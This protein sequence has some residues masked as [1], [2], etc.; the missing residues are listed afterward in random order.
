M[1]EERIENAN[2]SQAEAVATPEAIAQAKATLRRQTKNIRRALDGEARDLAYADITAN[3]CAIPEFQQAKAVFAYVSTEDEVD[4][5]ALIARAWEAGKAVYAPR[6][7]GPRTMEWHAIE[8]FDGLERSAFGIDEPAADP[9]SAVD[10]A[11]VEDAVAIVPG[12]LFDTWGYRIGYG[13]GFY[14]EFLSSFTGISIG[15]A[16]AAFVSEAPLPTDE[17]DRTVDVIVTE[18]GAYRRPRA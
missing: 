10:P 1:S 4:T 3:V 2:E 5:R 18:S 7:V 14:D 16:R 17:H 15:I 6:V 12:L 8:S 11:V 9:A 13:G